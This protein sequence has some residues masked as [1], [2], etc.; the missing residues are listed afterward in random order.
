MSH[1]R[2]TVLQLIC[3][4]FLISA[5][6]TSPTSQQLLDADYGSFP[7]NYKAI[8]Q[9]HMAKRL[10]DPMSAVYDYSA[11]PIKMWYGGG[12]AGTF[13]FGWGLC[14][15][16][17]AKNGFGGYVGYRPYYFLI[18]NDSVIVVEDSPVVTGKICGAS[19]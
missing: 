12:L 3:F 8:I 17:N 13:K 19:L 7:E 2:S 5:C 9:D 18:R 1:L 10:K 14:T 15:S 6:A 11:M 4:L 16:I